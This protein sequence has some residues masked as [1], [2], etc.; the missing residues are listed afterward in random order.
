MIHSIIVK[1]KDDCY[2]DEV[3][4]DIQDSYARLVWDYDGITQTILRVGEETGP[5]WAD[6]VIYIGFKNLEAYETYLADAQ[7][8]QLL[9]R[10]RD[11]I[12]EILRFN[13]D[14]LPD[15]NH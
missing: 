7:H 11:K 8:T 4:Y 6:L 5:E 2:C 9:D 13:Y 12:D 3:L 14:N 1:F 10:H 15:L